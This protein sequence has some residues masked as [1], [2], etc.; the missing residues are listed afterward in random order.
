LQIAVDGVDPLRH[1]WF[2]HGA[3]DGN[4]HAFRDE[5]NEIASSNPIEFP[6]ADDEALPTIPIALSY[7]DFS[8][9]ANALLDTGFVVGELP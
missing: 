6:L 2:L 8:I 7:P 9:S 4:S 3:R 1:M 5:I